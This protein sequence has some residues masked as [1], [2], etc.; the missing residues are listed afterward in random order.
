MIILTS[1]SNIYSYSVSINPSN[2]LG[3]CKGEIS[4]Y[5]R[6]QYKIF[7][8]SARSDNQVSQL[9]YSTDI[10]AQAVSL[11]LTA[12]KKP[13]P[14]LAGTTQFTLIIGSTAYTGVVNSKNGKVTYSPGTVTALIYAS[15]S[16]PSR[17]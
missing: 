1:N 10:S 8:F 11:P 17:R 13:K 12:S 14:T 16:S 9:S 2:D 15:R 7:T 4:G 6:L 3:K 5:R